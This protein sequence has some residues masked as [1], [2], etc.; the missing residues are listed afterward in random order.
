NVKD[1]WPK[2]RG[3]NRYFGIIPGGANYYTPELYSDNMRYKA[4]DDFYLT[5]A[6]SD[7]TVKFMDDHFTKQKD[8]PMFMYVAYTAPHWPLH[9][10]QKDIDKYKALYQKGW[11]VMRTE[12]FERQREMGFFA[13]N[14][15]MSPRDP[16]IP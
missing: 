9:A 16:V 7:T 12:R 15:V 3:F 5:N 1:N 10:L 8:K 4:P 13:S 2:Q 6:I 11:D 14:L